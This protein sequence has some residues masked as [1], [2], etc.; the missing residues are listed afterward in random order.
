MNSPALQISDRSLTSLKQPAINTLTQVQPHGAILVL[1]EPDMTVLQISRNVS[2]LFGRPAEDLIGKS[3]EDIL[4]SYQADRF[5]HALAADNL[6]LMNP[7][8]VWVRRVGD[9]Y[10][11]FDAI[12]HRSA[13]GFLVLELEPALLQENIPFL[14]FYHLAKVSINQLERG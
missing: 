7:T 5:L 14:G 10:G 9:D 6:D 2:K 8:K 1:K 11:V 3:L 13:D 4:D 12:V